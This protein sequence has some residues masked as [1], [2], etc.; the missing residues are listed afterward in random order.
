MAIDFPDS[1]ENGELFTISGK[2]WS[3]ST[4]TGVWDLTGGIVGATGPTGP[5]GSLGP[6]GPQGDWSAAQT[7]DTKSDSYTLLTSDVGKLVLMD[8]STAQ[9]VTINGSLDLT[10]G[11]RIDVIQ[12]GA[13]QVT[14]VASGATVNATPGLKT[15]AQ[16]SGATVIC[17]GTDSYVVVGDL[18]A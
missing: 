8:K 18:S 6:T 17:V 15:R 14:F 16:Y 13:G 12:T 7:A 3:Y 9:D 5:T 4:T 11:Q 10:V 1:P 2:T